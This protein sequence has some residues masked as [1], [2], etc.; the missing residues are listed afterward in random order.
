[1]NNLYFF[2]ILSLLFSCN[3]K[4]E[5]EVS[6]E[7]N[8]NQVKTEEFEEIDI[9]EINKK[10]TETTPQ[11]LTPTE[12]MKIYYPYKA[13]NQ[14]GN[15]IITMNTTKL[16]NGI[17]EVTLIHDNLIDDSVKGYKYIMSLKQNNSKWVVV[18]LKKNWKC[19]DKRGHTN[20]GIKLCN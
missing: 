19:R 16:N 14:E 12:I 20:W 5:K 3:Q 18:S 17:I 6:D 8:D 7:L 2:L 11:K 1:M 10:I 15:E 9:S 4:Q 13:D